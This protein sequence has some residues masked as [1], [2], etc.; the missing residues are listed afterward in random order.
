MDTKF[1][2]V[3]YSIGLQI[4]KIGGELRWDDLENTR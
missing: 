4:S 3:V 2:V 1:A